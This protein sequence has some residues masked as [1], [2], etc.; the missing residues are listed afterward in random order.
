[1]SH[2]G[3]PLS[4]SAPLAALFQMIKNSQLQAVAMVPDAHLNILNVL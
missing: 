4:P 3:R 1:M 2:T